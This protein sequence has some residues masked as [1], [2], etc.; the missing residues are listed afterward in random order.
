METYL[1]LCGLGDLIVTCTSVHSRNY[2]AGFQIGKADSA[3]E[4]LKTNTKTVEGINTVKAVYAMAKE[5]NV[6][7]PIVN[8]L[9]NV[10]YMGGK[11]SECV[12]ELMMR[13]LVPEIY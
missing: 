9:Y 12:D 7:M 1:G 6:E 4:F 3:E 2:Q 10:L 5:M 11:P 13:K 8:Q